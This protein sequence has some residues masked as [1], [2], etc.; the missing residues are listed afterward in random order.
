M[1]DLFCYQSAEGCNSS[2]NGVTEPSNRNILKLFF[3]PYDPKV[4][5]PV[6]APSYTVK[7][8]T[9]TQ[10]SEFYSTQMSFLFHEDNKTTVNCIK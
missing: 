7:Y 4:K 10:I 6:F 3:I 2:L 1:P 5:N 8:T 9:A